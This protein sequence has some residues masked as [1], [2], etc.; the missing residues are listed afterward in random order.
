MD[1]LRALAATIAKMFATDL[2]LTATTVAAVA[3]CAIGLHARVLPPEIVPFVLAAGVVVA[4]V[5]GVIR[6]AR[7]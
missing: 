4:L 3:I 1:V 7:R 5:V 6:G 2:W